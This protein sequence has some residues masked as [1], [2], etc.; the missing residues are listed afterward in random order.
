MLQTAVFIDAG[1]LYAQG[2]VL[3]SGKRQRREDV[4]LN[5]AKMLESLRTLSSRKAPGGRLLRIYW[6]DALQRGGSLS[7]EQRLISESEDVKFRF[8]TIN[9]AGE[10][11]GVD[12]L[13]VTDMVDLARNRVISDALLLSGDEDIRIGVQ[14]AQTYGV[15]VHLLGIKPARGSQSP[16]L[17]AE[18]DTL[19]EWDDSVVSNW[20]SVSARDE[21]SPV[22]PIEIKPASFQQAVDVVVNER[23]SSISKGDIISVY[24]YLQANSNQLPGDFDRPSLARIRDV[25]GRDLDPKERRDFRAALVAA[26]SKSATA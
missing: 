26:V 4:R 14:L 8:G 1:Y 3:L 18:S 21:S 19:C 22:L 2:S 23:V 13:I 16:D 20:M 25:L 10:Q 12:S 7:Q 15:R 24:Q 6:Y 11:K 5:V 17:I 9:G